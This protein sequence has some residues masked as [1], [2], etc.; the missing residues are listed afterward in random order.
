MCAVPRFWAHVFEAAGQAEAQE[1]TNSLACLP[2][3]ANVCHSAAGATRA[4]G[5]DASEQEHG[6]EYLTHFPYCL[7]ICICN[8]FRVSI[9]CIYYNL[10]RSKGQWELT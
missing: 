10:F 3:T 7:L 2:L 8:N 4:T 1:G 6:P 5:V 9:F